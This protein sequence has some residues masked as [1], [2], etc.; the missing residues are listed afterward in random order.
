VVGDA[1]EAEQIRTGHAASVLADAGA[2]ATVAA[3]V[4]AGHAGRAVRGRGDADRVRAAAVCVSGLARVGD[5]NAGYLGAGGADAVLASLSGSAGGEVGD[6][7]RRIEAARAAGR[8]V[9]DRPLV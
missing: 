7:Q 5:G 6:E 9:D 4:V 1:R 3:A 8:A 2:V